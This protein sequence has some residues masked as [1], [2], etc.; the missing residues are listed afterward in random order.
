MI[1]EQ[2]ENSIKLL[3]KKRY[4]DEK[5][6]QY[7]LISTRINQYLKQTNTKRFKRSLI[8]SFF[9]KGFFPLSTESKHVKN[10]ISTLKELKFINDDKIKKIC[11]QRRIYSLESNDEESYTILMKKNGYSDVIYYKWY[12]DSDGIPRKRKVATSKINCFPVDKN[13]DSVDEWD[14]SVLKSTL[15]RVKQG[16]KGLTSFSIATEKREYKVKGF[17]VC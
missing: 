13:G 16:V 12:C 9:D 1:T 5:K 14:L 11:R 2:I 4:S 7:V 17:I 6:R 10:I 8:L 3:K 15:P